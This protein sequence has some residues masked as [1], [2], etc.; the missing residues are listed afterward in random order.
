[1]RK[2]SF[3]SILV[4]LIWNAH[5]QILRKS[6][7]TQSAATNTKPAAKPA[8]EKPKPIVIPIPEFINQPYYYDA[9]ENKLIKL[10]SSAAQL[11]TKKKTLGLKGSKQSLT[12]DNGSSKIRFLAKNS[13]N[14]IIKTSGDVID[15][16]TYIKLY[17]F[18]VGNEKR[19]V[20]ISAKEG[21]FNDKEEQ[22]GKSISF[23]VKLI[24]ADNYLIE[25]SDALE[26]GEYGFAWLKNMELK[27]CS[28]FAFGIDW[29]NSD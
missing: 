21:M 5:A 25:F 8:P 23:S 27:E 28:V 26:A 7:V 14:F 12:M 2:I 9:R 18:T 10:E 1:M 16:T 17:K 19:E 4:F 15:L 20:N 22:K 3:S 13:L 29:K 6:E 11:V 24:S